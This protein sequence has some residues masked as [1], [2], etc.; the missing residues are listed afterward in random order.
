[1]MIVFSKCNFVF[2]FFC[3]SRTQFRR[4]RCILGDP[5]C[6]ITT[7]RPCPWSIIR[8]RKTINRTYHPTITGQ[9][10]CGVMGVVSAWTSCSSRGVPLDYISKGFFLYIYL[11]QC[12]SRWS[13]S[14][15]AWRFRSNSFVCDEKKNNCTFFFLSDA[16]FPPFFLPSFWSKIVC[17]FLLLS[18]QKWSGKIIDVG[19]NYRYLSN[20]SPF[21]CRYGY[22]LSFPGCLV[23]CCVQHRRTLE[24]RQRVV[25]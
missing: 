13:V 7:Y 20:I 2:L 25:R 16:I 11:L 18:E 5:N 1:M 17:F 6:F 15:K 19:N 8:R 10:I 12:S 14:K 24:F 9:W 22:D 21:L 3:Y 4:R 23:C